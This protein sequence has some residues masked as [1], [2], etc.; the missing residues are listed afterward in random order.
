[1]SFDVHANNAL[2]TTG[3]DM[4]PLTKSI[5]MWAEACQSLDR[6]ERMHRRFFEPGGAREHVWEPPVDIVETAHELLIEIA[7][8]GVDPRSASVSFAS[9][10]LLIAAERRLPQTTQPAVI[11]RLELPYGRIERRLPLPN[12]SFELAKSEFLNGCLMIVLRKVAPARQ[13]RYR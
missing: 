2:E 4:A 13:E 1:M 5:W 9:G 10:A 7:L 8:P 6:A 12:G 11:R 3:P